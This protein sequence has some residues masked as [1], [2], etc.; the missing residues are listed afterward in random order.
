MND[1]RSAVASWGFRLALL[2]VVISA[3]AVAGNRFGVMPFQMALLGLAGGA[4]M[5]L[6]AALVSLIGF[7]LAGARQQDGR[8][9]ATIGFVIGILVALPVALAMQKG[10]GVPRIHDIT[11]D[12]ADPPAFT[13]LAE[14]RPEHWNALDRASPPDLADQQRKAYGDL[15]PLVIDLPAG[16]VY[17]TALDLVRQRGWQIVAEDK[18]AGTIEAVATTTVM[19]FEDDIILRMRAA[20]GATRVDMRSVSRVGESDLGANAERIK[21][22]LA[23]LQSALAGSGE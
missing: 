6:L 15:A 21:L 7:V 5:G 1:N 4:A 19:G 9:S 13:A 11:T 16:L 8:L 10:A 14:G 20:G 18:Q 12:L 2:A 23:D 17:D 3:L 22:F